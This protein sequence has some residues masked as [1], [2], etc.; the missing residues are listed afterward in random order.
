M[1]FLLIFIL[2]PL[3]ELYLM[4][5]VGDQIGALSTVLLVVF[6][7]V[8]G[9]A[10]VRRQGFAVLT[11]VQATL[12]RGEPPALE[13][14]EGALLLV[15]GLALLVPGF[16]TDALGFL[17]LVPPLRERLIRAALRRMQVHTDVDRRP[18]SDRPPRIIEGDWTRDRDD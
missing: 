14:M 10:L 5:R 12:A 3:A 13:M 9:V 4:I 8:V 15:A 7:A 2:V 6:T 1:P 11:R 18:P 17:L 16:A